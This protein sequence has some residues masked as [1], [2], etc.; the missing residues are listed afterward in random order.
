MRAQTGPI[1]GGDDAVRQMTAA[2]SDVNSN[3]QGPMTNRSKPKPRENEK[4][5]P[6]AV[7]VGVSRRLRR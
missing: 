2:Q 7:S 6:N 1:H 5:K 4:A 3:D